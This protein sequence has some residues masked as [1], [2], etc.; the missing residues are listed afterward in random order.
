ME[1]ADIKKLEEQIINLLQQANKNLVKA[2]SLVEFLIGEKIK[3]NNAPR[4]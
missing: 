1:D 4:K 3:G 2:I